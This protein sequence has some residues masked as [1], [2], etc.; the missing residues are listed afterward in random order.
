MHA[1][2]ALLEKPADRRVGAGRRE[3]FHHRPLIETQRHRMDA[4]LRDDRFVVDAR[5]EHR[6]VSRD[7]RVDVSHRDAEMVDAAHAGGW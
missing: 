3:Q 4:L 1:F 5:A 6:G 7:C 2:A